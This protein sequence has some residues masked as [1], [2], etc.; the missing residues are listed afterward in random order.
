MLNYKKIS[1]MRAYIGSMH[2]FEFRIM[3][4]FKT[5]SRKHAFYW[6]TRPRRQLNNAIYHGYGYI[7]AEQNNER[8]DFDVGMSVNLKSTTVFV[9][10]DEIRIKY[11]KAVF[12]QENLLRLKST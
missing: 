7:A 10:T 2:L 5:C 12:Y 3:H 9:C 4:G 11:T 8:H 6:F 1:L